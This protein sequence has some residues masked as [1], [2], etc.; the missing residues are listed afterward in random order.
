MCVKIKFK[1]LL[2]LSF[3]YLLKHKIYTFKPVILCQIQSPIDVTN[4]LL[5][6]LVE[7][8]LSNFS[9]SR[10]PCK[11]FLPKSI[12]TSPLAKS[13]SCCLL[14][15]KMELQLFNF[16]NKIDP[17]FKISYLL[18]KFILC[19]KALQKVALVMAIFIDSI[20]EC[21]FFCN[22]LKLRKH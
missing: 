4:F 20:K 2:Q 15:A 21:V 16:P 7:S 14:F 12:P 19:L 13:T 1:D 5:Q 3:K 18:F 6:K 10:N 22:L 17:A 9:Y 11:F 8:S